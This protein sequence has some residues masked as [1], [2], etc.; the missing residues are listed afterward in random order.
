M[1]SAHDAGRSL[2]A[3]GDGIATARCPLSSVLWLVVSTVDDALL[4]MR[5]EMFSHDADLSDGY[6]PTF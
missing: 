5:G 6:P 1:T 3:V 4:L 2:T